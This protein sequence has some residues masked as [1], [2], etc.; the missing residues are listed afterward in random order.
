MIKKILHSRVFKWATR[1]ISLFLLLV[2]LLV[3]SVYFGMWGS[4]PS[5]DELRNLKQ[6]EATEVFSYDG[7]LIGKFYIFDRQP[8]TYSDLPDYLIDALIATEDIRFFEHSGI[9]N[10]SLLRVFVKSILLQDESAGGGSTI[11]Q[12]LAKNLY[13]REDYGSMGI[14]IHKIRENIIAKRLENIYDKQQIL[15]LYFNTVPFSDN[16]FGIESAARKFFHK[17]TSE[18]TLEEA[19][20]LVGTL[21]A[22]NYYNP[23]INPERSRSRR[24]VVISQMEKYGF[25]S[26]EKEKE[27]MELPIDINYHS[28]TQEKGTAT[29][30]REQIRQKVSKVLDTLKNQQG[31][32][33]NIYRDGLKIY[34]TLDFEMQQFAE[35]AMKQ[36]MSSLQQQ[37][38]EAYGTNPPW[39]RNTAA[40]ENEI[41]QNRT[42]KRLKEKGLSDPEII[43]A[44]NKKKQME[45][46]SWEGKKTIQASTIDSIRHYK[47]FL[48]AGMLA[49]DPNTGAIRSYIGGI[50]Y[51]HF[52]YDHVVQSKRQVGSTFKPI[53]YTAAIENGIDPCTY[54]PVREVTYEGG[55]TPSN[56]G[57]LD[58]DP[59]MQY[60]MAAA[61]SQSI[62]TIA[63]KVLFATGINNV[64]AQATRMGI[65]SDLPPYPS[66]ALGTPSLSVHEMAG[67]YSSYLNEGKP[68]SP[69]FLI[70][71]EDKDGNLIANFKPKEYT[72]PAFSETTRQIML[73]MM[74][75]TVN[76]GTATRLRTKYNLNNE[77]AGK[78][79]TTQDNRDGWFVGLAPNLVTVTWVGSDDHRFGFPNTAI[80]Q[81][82]NSALPIFAL[83]MQKLNANAEFNNIT[84]ASFPPTSPEVM[85]MMDCD[86]K[87]R[88]NFIERLFQ[89]GKE[90]R[91][92]RQQ[93][94]K[95]EKKGL[96]KK[97]KGWFSKD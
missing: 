38:E 48:N 94:G 24:D 47:K 43:A 55:W 60:S 77:L 33:Y 85:E 66:I 96:F 64:I 34:T 71:I 67:A 44:L 65:K 42:Y 2:L 12:Q 50:D 84:K 63:V 74:K 28:F 82:A 25:I 62:N 90:K 1:I 8:I 41:K 46:F 20:V 69:Y 5:K 23:R 86:N 73:E 31:D 7:K 75:E 17:T 95:K 61:L 4:I 93:E 83:L 78:T 87:K 13:G 39:E 91:A 88:Q 9:D 45:V 49:V 79:G 58:E 51:E 29:Y 10:R 76:S 57:N 18:L 14:V 26:E 70:K 68:T 3:A 22:S 54:F 52:Q 59:N 27:V 97:I 53:V 36:H 89:S 32:P 40:I 6:S 19:A 92:Q 16:T 37:F 30:L 80:G 81:G 21:K 11:T 35:E 56:S 15:T 72:E